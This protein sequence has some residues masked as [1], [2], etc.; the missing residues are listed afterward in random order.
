MKELDSLVTIVKQSNQMDL[1]LLKEGIKDLHRCGSQN[2]QSLMENLEKAQ[3]ALAAILLRKR[4]VFTKYT[5]ATNATSFE[6]GICDNSITI[7]TQQ[8]AYLKKTAEALGAKYKEDMAASVAKDTASA[9]N[10]AQRL[11][12]FQTLTASR[13]AA[14][15]EKKEAAFNERKGASESQL[16][17]QINALDAEAKDLD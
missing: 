14:D 15:K 17:E 8:I 4:E 13:L 16:Q 1:E 6:K 12:T 7:Y 9:A 2:V 3:A 10:Q 11:V 5:A